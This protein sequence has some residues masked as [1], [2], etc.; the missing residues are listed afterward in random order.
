M[1]CSSEGVFHGDKLQWI[2]TNQER[3]RSST[4]AVMSVDRGVLYFNCKVE[5]ADTDRN[6]GLTQKAFVL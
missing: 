6:Y 1:P 3:A 4:S 2:I 5:D